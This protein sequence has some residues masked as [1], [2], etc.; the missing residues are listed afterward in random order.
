MAETIGGDIGT[1]ILNAVQGLGIRMDRFEARM[2]KLEA[3]MD[4][5][6]AQVTDLKTQVTDLKTQVT[7]LDSRMKRQERLME[8]LGAEFLKWREGLSGEILQLRGDMQ[9]LLTDL[10][11][12]FRRLNARIDLTDGAVVLMASVLRR[13]TDLGENLEKRLQEL[14]T[15]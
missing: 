14:Q 1:Q 3:R 10:H 7:S 15:H 2:D 4:G 12:G 9:L 6:E 8:S 13:P 11:E 5:L